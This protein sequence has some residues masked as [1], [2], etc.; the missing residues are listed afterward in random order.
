MNRFTFSHK[1][2]KFICMRLVNLPNSV[3]VCKLINVDIGAL[4]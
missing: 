4:G 2:C 1:Y 3:T